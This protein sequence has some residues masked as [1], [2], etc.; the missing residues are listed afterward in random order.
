MPT[1]LRGQYTVT[2]ENVT[3]VGGMA[4]EARAAGTNLG[5][6]RS[7]TNPEVDLM[8]EIS[9]A[10]TPLQ[11]ITRGWGPCDRLPWEPSVDDPTRARVETHPLA[12]LAESDLGDRGLAERGLGETY[13]F[14]QISVSALE[15][16]HTNWDNISYLRT[17]VQ[18][19][20]DALPLTCYA[21]GAGV[22]V[23]INGECAA[24]PTT[25]PVNAAGEFLFTIPAGVISGLVSSADLPPAALDLIF[26]FNTACFGDVVGA[27]ATAFSIIPFQYHAPSS[28]MGFQDC[29]SCLSA[30]CNWCE[31]ACDANC[32][33][34]PEWIPDY[35]WTE[36][37]HSGGTGRCGI[38]PYL[39][40]E[41]LGA[42][43]TCRADHGAVK[44]IL[45]PITF[46]IIPIALLYA[47]VQIRNKTW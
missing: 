44:D 14:V 45:W 6:G 8:T 3:A 4:A 37:A 25:G 5:S 24:W 26:T 12:V 19:S 35:S 20:L 16:R 42:F 41:T 23:Y 40:R 7:G 30:G 18:H 1:T 29:A 33:S 32:D 38:H 46:F 39:C 10:G 22:M 13:T 9:L 36:E 43:N 27:I 2:L 17:R 15:T 31:W 47:I 34:L 28:C 21:A 11:N